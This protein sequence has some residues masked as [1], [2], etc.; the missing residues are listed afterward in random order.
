[1]G[2]GRAP[3]WSNAHLVL[4][5]KPGTCGKEPDHYRFIGLQDQFGKL[6]LKQILDPYADDIYWIVKSFRQYGYVPGCSITDTLRE[7]V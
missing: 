4:I 1:M 2:A 6:T 5:K 3:P 7:S